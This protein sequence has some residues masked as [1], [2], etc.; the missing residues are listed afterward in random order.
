MDLLNSL[1]SAR[2]TTVRNSLGSPRKVQTKIA[3][4][5]L[6]FS[7]HR[8]QSSYE[9]RIPETFYFLCEGFCS[10]DPDMAETFLLPDSHVN[11]RFSRLAHVLNETSMTRSR[12]LSITNLH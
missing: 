2:F 5:L 9:D 1:C 4:L 11:I 7:S 12:E 10:G 8:S 6:R 3:V